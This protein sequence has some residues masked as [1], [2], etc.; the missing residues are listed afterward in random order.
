M[1]KIKSKRISNSFIR[2]CPR[3][4]FSF[5]SIDPKTNKKIK[6]CPMCGYKFIDPDISPNKSSENDYKLI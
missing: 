1:R 2:I 6:I 4:G 5:R 3:C